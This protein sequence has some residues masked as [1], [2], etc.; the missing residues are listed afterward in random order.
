MIEKK[1]NEYFKKQQ[2]QGSVLNVNQEIWRSN[3]QRFIC[4]KVTK[5]KIV[6]ER[7][8]TKYTSHNKKINKIQPT[9]SVHI[10]LLPSE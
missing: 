3:M 10:N 7:R 8:T 9:T 1:I 2:I 6:G 4:F 5:E